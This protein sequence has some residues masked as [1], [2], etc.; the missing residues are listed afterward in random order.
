MIFKCFAF[1]FF[2]RIAADL[3]KNLS[4]SM[5][6]LPSIEKRP[7]LRIP[8]SPNAKEKF[9]ELQDNINDNIPQIT[10]F[11]RAIWSLEQER[12][13]YRNYLKVFLVS[14]LILC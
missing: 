5:P 11:S 7:I 1:I 9:S 3:E 2:S 14:L 13:N 12:N 4:P 10:R 6:F 8:F